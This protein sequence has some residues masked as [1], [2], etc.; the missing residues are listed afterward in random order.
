MENE[1]LFYIETAW[2][3]S[4]DDNGKWAPQWKR[5][6]RTFKT[7]K[8]AVAAADRIEGRSGGEAVCRFFTKNGT[9]INSFGNPI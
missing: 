8:S 1:S 3:D 2:A 9:Q 4:Y 6:K 7:L 5:Y